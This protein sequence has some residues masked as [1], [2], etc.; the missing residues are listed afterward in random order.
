MN[1]RIL[2]ERDGA[3]GRV[4]FNNPETRNAFDLEMWQALPEALAEL[5]HNAE[6]RAIILSGAGDEAFVAGADISEFETQRKDPAA[7]T[8]YNRITYRAF[9]AIAESRAPT[10]AMIRGFCFGG[11]CAIALNSDLRIATADARFCI[12]AAKL[13]LGYGYENVQRLAD[14]LGPAVAR[15][16]LFTARVY[17]A[18]EALRIGLIHQ[19][20][21]NPAELESRTREYALTIARNAPLTIHSAKIALNE[22]VKGPAANLDVVNAA[23]DRCYDSA[24]YREG[25][26]AFL[27]KRKADFQGR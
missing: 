12:P 2:I 16:M 13:G 3:L 11:G 21:E 14:E 5:N 9:R 24:D 1:N 4:I 20:I 7:A 8:E 17:T 25:V 26:N 23:M 22:Y 19:L 15:E 18:E 6:I 27:E 10:I